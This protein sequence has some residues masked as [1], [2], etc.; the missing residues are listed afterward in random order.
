MVLCLCMCVFLSTV[1]F[2]MALPHKIFTWPSIINCD[3]IEAECSHHAPSVN[4][5][6]EHQVLKNPNSAS[7][8]SAKQTEA[9]VKTVLFYTFSYL[10]SFFFVFFFTAS[11][12]VHDIFYALVCM[13]KH[14]YNLAKKQKQSENN[15]CVLYFMLPNVWAQSH[16]CVHS[17]KSAQTMPL[18]FP[19]TKSHME[20]V[21]CVNHIPSFKFNC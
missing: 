5:Q 12:V 11:C 21:A 15:Y 20:F 9:R 19:P 1:I 18:A 17:F 16:S 10:L 13:G 3:L 6:H 7:F 14:L 8:Q 2:S 4:S